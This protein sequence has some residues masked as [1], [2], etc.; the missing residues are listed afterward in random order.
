MDSIELS[1][2]FLNTLLYNNWNNSLPENNFDFW[3]NG[4]DNMHWSIRLLDSKKQIS[5]FRKTEEWNKHLVIIKS[6]IFYS[7]TFAI[8]HID[9]HICKM[10]YYISENE[11]E[12]IGFLL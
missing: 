10:S 1:E 12:Y 9:F 3:V 11:T 4:I 7:H 2:E 8:K 6:L 5:Q